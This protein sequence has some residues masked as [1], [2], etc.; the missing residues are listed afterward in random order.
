MFMVFFIWT[1]M[2][3]V[4]YKYV[5]F[6][7]FCATKSNFSKE[8]RIKNTFTRTYVNIKLQL[9]KATAIKTKES[10]ICESS[11]SV[12]FCTRKSALFLLTLATR[13]TRSKHFFFQHRRKSRPFSVMETMQITQKDS[14]QAT[15]ESEYYILSMLNHKNLTY[16][17]S[18][19]VL[20][21]FW[22]KAL[23]LTVETKYI[24]SVEPFF[25]QIFASKLVIISVNF[26]RKSSSFYTLLPLS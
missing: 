5:F 26:M 20:N 16:Q 25:Q 4:L 3:A 2:S 1:N 8:H 12:F 15:V 13:T 17:Q 7:K 10:W 24:N 18:E 6:W 23:C 19:P 14:C 22:L 21:V 9:G 11:V